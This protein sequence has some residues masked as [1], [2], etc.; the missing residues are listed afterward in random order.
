[1]LLS[2]FYE[3]L[4]K[5]PSVVTFFQYLSCLKYGFTIAV[6]VLLYRDTR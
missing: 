6:L 1:M 4:H 2:G 5:L 3:N